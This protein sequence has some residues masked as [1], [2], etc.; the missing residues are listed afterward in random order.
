MQIGGAGI[1]TAALAIGGNVAPNPT[2]SWSN[3]IM[4]WYKSWTTSPVGLSTARAYAGAAGTQ[5]S[6]TWIFWGRYWNNYYYI[7][8]EFTGPSTT[9]NYKTLTTS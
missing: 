8:E 4:E 5:A 9:L 6:R 2:A 1:Q 3:R 7:Y